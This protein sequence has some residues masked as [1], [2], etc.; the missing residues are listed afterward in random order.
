[1]LKNG[2]AGFL[3]ALD[4]MK[5]VLAAKP[6]P[7]IVIPPD[8]FH[9]LIRSKRGFFGKTPFSDDVVEDFI[10]QERLFFHQLE[11]LPTVEKQMRILNLLVKERLS[12][13]F[14]PLQ[15]Y[16]DIQ[17]KFLVD[18]EENLLKSPDSQR[19]SPAFQDW[20]KNTELYGKLITSETRTKGILRAR[21]GSEDSG[22]DFSPQFDAIAACFKLVSLP[23]LTMLGHMEFLDNMELQIEE[24]D[25]ARSSDIAKSRTTLIEARDRISRTV[26][27]E[28]LS[29]VLLRLKR[30]MVDW[31]RLDVDQFGELLMY[32]AKVEMLHIAGT[33]LF[34]SSIS[35]HEMSIADHHRSRI[36]HVR[37]TPLRRYSF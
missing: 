35:I 5:G 34:V 32:D 16:I 19:W 27:R 24:P 14:T 2:D 25:E 33:R 29:D 9:G 4:V 23:V 12:A 17:L 36:R 37:C 21:L 30:D 7:A 13:I 8:R 31:K 18:I 22:R 6:E 26:K 20:A 1:M 10:A 3:R 11:D 28:D 15:K